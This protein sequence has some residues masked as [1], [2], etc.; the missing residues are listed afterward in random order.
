MTRVCLT[1]GTENARYED[2]DFVPFLVECEEC[3]EQTIHGTRE[4]Y[5]QR[6]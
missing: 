2:G 4:E 5:E 6:Q 1:C 3:G